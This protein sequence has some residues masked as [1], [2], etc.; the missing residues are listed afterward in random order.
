M[1]LK[2]KYNNEIYIVDILIITWHPSDLLE[3]GIDQHL[4][5]CWTSWNF[6]IYSSSKL[7]IQTEHR[8]DPEFKF[9]YIIAM[10]QNFRKKMS[11]VVA[12]MQIVFKVSIAKLNGISL[13]RD[14]THRVDPG[15]LRWWW[16]SWH[17]KWRDLIGWGWSRDLNAGLWL[18]LTCMIL[19]SGS[20]MYRAVLMS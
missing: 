17:L 16:C 13:R 5:L 19:G 6:S 1:I 7:R 15:L 20:G 18:V 2:S 9:I 3:A 12:G 8:S 11:A 10:I 4:I 14:E